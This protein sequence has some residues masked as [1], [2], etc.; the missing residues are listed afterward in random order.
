MLSNR[1]YD[2][3]KWVSI[4][5]MPALATFIG[6]VGKV[7]GMPNVDAWVTT[8]NAVGIFLGAI[9]GVSTSSYNKDKGDKE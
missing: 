2:I 7:W 4:L 5:L 3:L 9:I 6:V 1:A 8:I